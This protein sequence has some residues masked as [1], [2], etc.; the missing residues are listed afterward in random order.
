MSV[1]L[2]LV[3]ISPEQSIRDAISLIDRNERGIVIVVDEDRRVIDTITD[4]DVRRAMLAGIDLGAPVRELLGRRAGSPYPA[5]VTAL[6]GT[7]PATLLQ[8]M[9][10]QQLRQ[11]PIVDAAAR[12]VDL[13]TLDELLPS[14]GPVLQAVVMAGGQGTRL[15]PLTDDVPKPMLPVGGRPIM[16]LIIEQL[17]QAGI[18]H[19]N[20]TTHYRPDKIIDHFGNGES[21]GVQLRYVNETMPL[22]TAGALGLMA[23]PTEPVLV[24]NGDILTHVDFR[25]MLVYHQEHQADLTVAVR[26]YD[27]KVPYGVVEC[28]GAAVRKLTEKPEFHVF[29]NAGIY[30]L[31]PAAFEHI[32][33][34]EHFDMTQLIQRLLDAGRPVVSFLVHEYWLDI[35]QHEDYARAQ[36]EI[37]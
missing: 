16:E 22:G 14:L 15:R 3:C 8:L 10:T 30:L 21:F 31:A 19:V 7:D 25:S 29:V 33:H 37:G 36:L 18:R 2:S 1:D 5:P 4:G 9:Q 11:I 13:I 27:V 20:I 26:R 35:G 12:V 34:D 23:V 17:Q 28:E 32:P 6:A 24:I